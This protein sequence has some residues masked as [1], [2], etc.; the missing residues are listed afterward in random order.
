MLND[1]GNFI[2]EMFE[3]QMN[4]K[5]NSLIIDLSGRDVVVFAAGLLAGMI[6]IG[7]VYGYKTGRQN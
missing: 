1:F 7:V 3:A 4:W 5:L 2:Q 6:I